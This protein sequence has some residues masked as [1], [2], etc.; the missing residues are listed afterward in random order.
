MLPRAGNR[1]PSHAVTRTAAAGLLVALTAA[2]TLAQEP[3]VVK[4]GFRGSMSEAPALTLKATAGTEGPDEALLYQPMGLLFGP[5]GDLY[6]PDRG[7]GAILVYDR[8]GTFK[9]RIGTKGSGPGEFQLPAGPYFSWKGELV[10]PDPMNQRT[11]FFTPEG[12]FL[13]SEPMAATGMIIIGG[14]HIPSR[15]GEYIRSGSGGGVRMLVVETG[16]GGGRPPELE[17]PKLVEIVDDDGRVLR[18]F[19]ELKRHED[20]RLAMA[21][22]RTALDYDRRRR[23]IAVAYQFSP[24][25]TIYDEESGKLELIVTRKLPFTPREPEFDERRTTSPDGRDVRVSLTMV[26]DRITLD[27]A[28]DPEGRLWAITSLVDYDERRRREEEGDYAGMLR[29]EVYG[30]DGRLLTTVGIEEPADVIAF[31]P[32]G[33]LWLM[34]SDYK[35]SVRRYEVTWP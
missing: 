30:P 18:A 16:P 14:A 24:E 31:D 5:N 3:P 22:N 21:M 26:A 6:I 23:K 2:T 9:K 7:N 11:S 34:D 1:S 32:Q 13:R 4:N 10:V 17:E 28:Y 19:G 15:K 33:D 29:L 35:L 8:D 25:I 12:E 27:V 20:R